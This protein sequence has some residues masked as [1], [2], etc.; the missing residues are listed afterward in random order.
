MLDLY[1]G[2]KM[3]ILRKN[4]NDKI[5]KSKEIIKKEKE[6]IRNEKRKIKEEKK[7]KFYNTKFGKIL[8]KITLKTDNTSPISPRHQIFS[9]LYFEFLGFLLCLLILFC[10]SGGRNFIKLYT[11][12]YK[13]INVYDTIS[14]NYYGDL[15]KDKLI[16]NAIDSMLSGTG[17]DYT[18]YSN[19]KDTNSFLE[20]VE[21]TY[22]GI[23]CMVSMN[24][25]GNII[26]VN[27]FENSPAKSAGLQVGD[28]VL[29]VDG[30][31]YQGKT[32]EDMSNYVKN[33]HKKKVEFIIKRGDE[34]KNINVTTKKVE[35]PS[36]TSKVID[37]EG[38]KVGYI[39]IT[40][41]SS[42]T[43]DQFKKQLTELEKKKIQAL[44]IDVRNDSGGYLN[45]VT[46]ISSIFLKKGKVIYQLEDNK[47]KEIIKDKTKES[48]DYPIAILVNAA[49]ASASEILASAIKESY[50]GLVV[51]TQTF[52]KGTVQ[53]TK[54]LSDGTMIKYTIQKWLTPNGNWI[55]EVGVTPTNAVAYDTNSTDDNQLQKAIDL[56]IKKIK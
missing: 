5:K 38:K 33:N 9:I 2:D 16:D 45:S 34:E 56:L 50:G 14:N 23:G 49:S 32:S 22:D 7:E 36:V 27:V 19:Q 17:D 1:Q 47:K 39:D 21:G 3:R 52:G 30:E 46:D 18:T 42:V 40:I 48:R 41:F 29:K 55:N 6:K 43:Y 10:L 20:T 12:L 31:D 44:I 13:L 24:E 53:K 8:K 51:G 26:I 4:K 15:D 54:K 37:S 11:D 28:I 25:N 35:V